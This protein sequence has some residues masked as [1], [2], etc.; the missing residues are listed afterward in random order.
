MAL[1]EGAMYGRRG[2][3]SIFVFASGNGGSNWDS[4]VFDGYANSIYTITVGAVTALGDLPFY[5]ESCPAQ[6]VVAYSGVQNTNIVG[7]IRDAK[8]ILWRAFLGD[9]GYSAD[10]RKASL[11]HTGTFG[12][13]CSCAVRCG[14][15]CSPAQSQVP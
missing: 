10:V 5:S 13:F 8:S 14:C 2:L 6:M 11:L 15:H 3:G 4:C 1:T 12:N 7:P 9:D